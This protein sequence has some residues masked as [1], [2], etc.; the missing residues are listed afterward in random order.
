MTIF[1]SIISVLIVV[2]GGSIYV[3]NQKPQVLLGMNKGKFHEITNKPNCVSSQTSFEDKKVNPLPFKGTKAESVQLVK[4]ALKAYGHIEIKEEKADYIYA[5]ATTGKMKYHDDIELYFDETTNQIH[6]R[7]SSRAG[8][9]DMG[10]NRLR[11]E[12]IV[13]L[14]ENN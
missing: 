11:Y 13:A 4:D 1:L 3:Q 9:S 5:V 14:Y 7:S 10:L 8:Y 6:Y 12:K 2:M